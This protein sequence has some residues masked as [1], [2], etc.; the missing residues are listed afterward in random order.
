MKFNKV[1]MFLLILIIVSVSVGSIY[2]Q[3]SSDVGI[4]STE[5]NELSNDALELTDVD[6]AI[7]EDCCDISDMMT[8]T[9]GPKTWYVSPDPDNP[10]QVQKPTV[11]PVINEANPGDTIV[12]NGS[13]VHCHFT[14]NKTLNIV[15]APGANV[16]VCPHHNHPAGSDTFGVFYL[17]PESNGTVIE[18]FEFTNDFFNLA[19]VQQNPFAVLIDGASD[20]ELKNLIINWTGVQTT[21]KDPKDYVLSPIIIKNAADITLNN[22]FINNT[23]VGVSIVN[24]SDI[25][26][27]NST[28]INSQENGIFIGENSSDIEITDNKEVVPPVVYATILTVK[29]LK[30]NAGNSGNLKVTLTDELGNAL[31]NQTVDIIINGNSKSVVTDENGTADLSVKY[32]AAG[33]YYATASFLGDSTYKASIAPAKIIVSKKATTITAPKKTFKVK[34]TKKVAITLKSG[35]SVIKNKKVTVKVNG[36]TYTAKTNKKGVAT[37]TVKLTKKGT[38]KYTAKFAG[39]SAYKAVSKTGKIVVKK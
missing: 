38:F 33:T 36:K 18:G 37:V 16:G 4:N 1:C 2:A 6:D 21:D 15:A 28:I 7:S 5:I 23:K 9:T 11:Q 12:L 19:M 32:S 22:L 13:F 25:K 29:D 39:D 35:K 30:I 27:L 14:I 3:D 24:S 26:I 31:S 8:N 17:T 34:S 10:N 20:I